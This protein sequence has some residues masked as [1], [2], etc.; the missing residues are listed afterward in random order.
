MCKLIALFH[1]LIRVLVASS[2]GATRPILRGRQ[3]GNGAELVSRE[4]PTRREARRPG[5][6]AGSRRRFPSGGRTR[7][8]VPGEADGGLVQPRPAAGTRRRG[9]PSMGTGR[10]AATVRRGGGPGGRSFGGVDAG[11]AIR[12]NGHLGGRG[13]GEGPGAGWG[14]GAGPIPSGVGA[15]TTQVGWMLRRLFVPES[16]GSLLSGTRPPRP[17]VTHLWFATHGRAPGRLVFGPTDRT[18]RRGAGSRTPG[19]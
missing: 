14:A 9:N 3:R 17:C 4:R 5:A 6:Q 19:A 18:M 12:T 10:K 16:T 2:T 1:R 15:V 7:G 11:P 13:Y 8:L